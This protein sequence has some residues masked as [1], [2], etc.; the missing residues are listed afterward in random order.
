MSN[1][2]EKLWA[3]ITNDIE[4]ELAKFFSIAEDTVLDALTPIF[5]ETVR[6]E[7]D[8]LVAS[9]GDPVKFAAASA[10]ILSSAAT[11]AVTAGIEATGA[12]LLQAL[13]AAVAAIEPPTV[14]AT[15]TPAAAPPPAPVPT[16]S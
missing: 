15:I 10:T 1:I 7:Q 13:A 9:A 11:K 6:E 3:I 4:P 16:E 2:L 14:T 12:A 5:S 8:A